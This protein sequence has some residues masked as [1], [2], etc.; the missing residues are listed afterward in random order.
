M[1]T[2]STSLL[3]LLREPGRQRAWER[4]V[5]LYGP[6][7]LHWARQRLPEDEA[8]E[9]VQEIFTRLL[10]KLPQFTYEPGKRFRGWLYT[11]ALHCRH[12]WLRRRGREP[13][14]GAPAVEEAAGPDN[15]AEFREEEHRRYLVRR[16]L[17]VMRAEFEPATWRACWEV[18][19]EGRPA[20]EV[21]AELGISPNAVYIARHR[22][23]R[24]L[25]QELDGLL[26]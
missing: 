17:A 11:V 8:E 15:V 13:A 18:A 10:E 1:E 23:L 5:D 19:A 9:L 12:D 16:A 6:L 22:V 14:G 2:T 25:R 3:R 21:A 7:L 26:D 4:F 24:R 20:A